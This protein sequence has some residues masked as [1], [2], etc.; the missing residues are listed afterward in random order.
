M[1][2]FSLACS[3]LIFAACSA[4][5]GDLVPGACDTNDDCLA[6]EWCRMGACQ[7]GTGNACEEDGD[8]GA[9]EVCDVVTDCGATRCSGNTCVPAACED[10]EDCDEGF[11]CDD[12][13]C[14]AGPDCEDDEDCEA[15][16]VCDEGT[17]TAPGPCESD[18]ECADG[19]LCVDGECGPPVPCEDRSDCED[20]QMCFDGACRDACTE[21]ADCAP[22]LSRCDTDA[23]ECRPGCFNDGQCPEGT[24]CEGFL[25]VDAECSSDEECDGQNVFCDGGRCADFEPCGMNGDCPT[26]FVCDEATMRCTA[27]PPC[28]TDRD[29]GPEAYC[30][31]GYCQ[32]AASC[33]NMTCAEGFECIG[34]VCVP[35]PC[36]G[37]ADCT[38]PEVC[39]GGV[40]GE[41]PSTEFVTEVRIVSPAGTVRP[42][43]TYRH[44]ALALD[45]AGR[46]VPGVTFDWSSTST[47][48]ATIAATGVATGGAT[49]GTTQIRAS[50]DSGIGPV[51]S[52]PVVLTNL[53]ALAATDLR[54]SVSRL[55]GGLPVQGAQI[56]VLTAGGTDSAVTDATGTAVFTRPS[57]AFTVTAA[58][59]DFDWVSV[60]A[61]TTYDLALALP[62]KSALGT[63]AGVKGDVDLARVG[64]Q[65]A[66]ELSL[67]GASLPS[68]LFSFDPGQ[69]FGTGNFNVEIPM[70][71]S[72]PIPAANT[73][74]IELM[75]FPLSLKDTYYAEA[76]P[77]VRAVWSFG[78]R[79]QLGAGGLGPEAFTNFLA[80]ILPFY[81]RFEHAVLPAVTLVARPDI[82]DANDVDGDGDTSEM[83]PDWSGFPT[84]RVEPDTEQ[85]LRYQLSVAPLPFVTGG[86]A[87]TLIVLSGTIVP[88]L[89][90][91]PL[92]LDGQ[93][94]MGGTGIV[95]SFVTKM[96]PRHGGLEAGT[97]A[98]LAIAVRLDGAGIAG[99]GSVRLY[100]SSRLPTAVALADG[101][102]DVPASTQW[103][104][105]ARTLTAGQPLG[106]DLFHATFVSANGG[107]HV[108]AAPDIDGVVDVPP[109]PMGAMDR[110]FS[111]EVTFD[112][113][114][115]QA[116]TDAGAIFDAA[117]GGALAVDEATRGFARAVVE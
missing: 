27:L 71:G 114:D 109:T 81:Q 14:V 45:Q 91:V 95:D 3:L 31:D 72:V 74:G 111:A 94:D 79:I 87:N 100:T 46:A 97:Y 65:G 17:C 30:E 49:A 8:C 7:P 57:G 69:L 41:A 26:G 35:S 15:G 82:V 98:V 50:V 34:D 115:L 11:L 10:H 39:I 23:M 29:C 28:R 80:A 36:R 89:G 38:A 5:T 24:I 25:C 1:R 59:T 92:G 105:M 102:L 62:P 37:D 84:R 4:D 19:D 113:I 56:E 53:G 76:Q 78:G 112:V 83:V 116:G 47:A 51:T 48:V 68:P 104:P 88:G 75:G 66:V 63:T 106:A 9:G 42:G 117:A 20:G 43:T 16:L 101:W 90:F 64:Q 6:T 33:A 18:D 58:H 99:P 108:Y 12:G 32:P 110:T 70:V 103:N 44:V 13:T 60:V 21:D 93:S 40:C 86:N 61:P 54:V 107:W 73:I 22:P 85:N 77:G 2:R 52:N 67:S 96:A 55:V